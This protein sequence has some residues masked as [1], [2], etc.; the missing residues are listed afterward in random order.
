[1]SSV[2][3]FV[4][5]KKY[6]SK[7]GMPEKYPGGRPYNGL[8]MRIKGL[9]STNSNDYSRAIV[10]HGAWY[11]EKGSTGRSWGCLATSAETNKQI[12]DFLGT[13]TFGYKFG[14]PQHAERLADVDML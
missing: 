7:A 5:V 1:M 12:V 13:G 10:I 14:G 9:D 8:S 2:G 4:S 11:R 3:A 6:Y